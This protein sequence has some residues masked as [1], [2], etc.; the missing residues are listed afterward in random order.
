MKDSLRT[1]LFL[2]A[3]LCLKTTASHLETLIFLQT[4]GTVMGTKYAPNCAT[5]VLGHLETKMYNQIETEK[6]MEFGIKIENTFK[7]YLNDQ[8]LRKYGITENS[9]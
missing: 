1:S 2:P 3:K 8:E 6:G 5:L 7:W 4:L 9:S